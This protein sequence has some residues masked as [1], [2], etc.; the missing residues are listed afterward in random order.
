MYRNWVVRTPRKANSGA[1][2][3]GSR[4]AADSGAKGRRW[5]PLLLL[6]LLPALA[7]T[8][9]SHP[10]RVSV[11]DAVVGEG[12][13]EI[14]I[15]FF[16]DDLQFALMEHTS[17]MEFRLEASAEVEATVERYINEML[18]IE[19]L[20]LQAEDR[21]LRGSVVARGVEGARRPD[22]VMWWYTL[23]YPL[24]PATDRIRVRNR[25][26]FNMFEDQRNL[27][28]LRTRSGRERSWY[29]TWDEDNVTVRTG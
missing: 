21:V 25:L 17:D 6:A 10:F 22:E 8:G 2:R 5:L 29:F 15:R 24:D 26:L 18:T 4:G 12:S 23:E 19:A 13:L 20:T 28:H 14:R 16:W 1:K 11:A 27:L 3:W 9:P 7:A